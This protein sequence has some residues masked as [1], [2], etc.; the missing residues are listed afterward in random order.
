[1]AMSVE[2]KGQILEWD[3]KKQ[4][5]KQT[6]RVNEVSEFLWRYFIYNSND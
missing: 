6:K 3:K 2:R 5:N 1:M 4:T